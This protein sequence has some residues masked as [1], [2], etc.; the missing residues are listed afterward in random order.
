VNTKIYPADLAAMNTECAGQKYRPSNG[1]EGEC[2]I[3]SW[4][5]QCVRDKSARE[6]AP[7][8][9]CDDNEVC[10]IIARTF[11]HE[12]SDPEYPG[13]WQ[14]GKDGQPC[15]TAFVLA[16]QPIPPAKDEHTV[17][18]FGGNQP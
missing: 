12:V 1:T 6:G 11:A 10:N 17:D 8:E 9:D 18:M 4:C 15:C 7:L 5:G 3:S 13:E 2:F 16:G 14:Y